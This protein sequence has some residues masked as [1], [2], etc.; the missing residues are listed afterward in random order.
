MTSVY[1]E[2]LRKFQAV[3]AAEAAN[4]RRLGWVRAGVFGVGVILYLAMD[5]APAA[6]RVPFGA[7]TALVG[8]GFLVL[9]VRHR[10]VKA[11][12]AR[13]EAMA[14]INRMGLARTARDWSGLPLSPIKDPGR[15]HPYA[16]DLDLTGEGSLTHLLS[17]VTLSPGYDRVQQWLFAPGSREEI[18]RRQVAVSELAESLELRQRLEAAGRR[19]DPPAPEDLGAFLS[20]AEAGGWLPERRWILLVAR[21]LPILSG[22]LLILFVTGRM[23]GPWCLLSL[24]AG[25]AFGYSFQPS[26]H[27][28]MAVASGG[29][30]SFSRY[31]DV[32]EILLEAD[33]TAPLL[34]DLQ[35]SFRANS[36]GAVR[37]LRSLAAIVGWADVRHSS[38]VHGPLQALLVWDLHVLSRLE[39]WQGRCGPH[40]RTWLSALGTLEALSALATLKAE[41]PD[42]CFPTI[43]GD[44]TD[45]VFKAE[46]MG[47]PLLPP[48]RRVDNDL[49]VG[50]PDSFLFVTGSNMSGKSTLL[51]SIGLN[52]VLALAGGP[53]CAD[54]LKMPRLRVHTAMRTVDSLSEGVSQYMAELSRIR[55]VVE[56]ARGPAPQVL[57]LL[58]EPLQGTNEAERR[59][60]IQTILGHLLQ[61]G[62]IGAVATHDLQLD[63][64]AALE[65]RARAVHMAGT[66]EEGPD[67]PLITFDYRVREGRATSTNALA[68][69]R[70]IGLGEVD[71][72][73]SRPPRKETSDHA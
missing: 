36:V 73:G 57:Y 66:V 22:V 42:W 29:E 56:D 8:L 65:T 16:G 37:E 30:E 49:S 27:P 54:A 53:V 55:Q 38:M 63:S 68:L 67:K 34:T 44:G 32:L 7:A 40:I 33:W 28:I 26:V 48:S 71:G 19:A 14:E 59:V 31:A 60:A 62:A 15:D 70:A 24:G 10:G 1:E 18:P 46:A 11:R 6:L 43:E 51:R 2:R 5:L 64:S 69:L 41:N 9:V 12:R 58:D 61:S 52:A 4:H 3:A 35:G 47:H 13:A 45:P 72:E 50:P 21:L 39:K 17:T 25:L 23:E 20:W